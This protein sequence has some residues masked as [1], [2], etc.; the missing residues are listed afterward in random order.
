VPATADL[1]P[2]D[3]LPEVTGADDARRAAWVRADTYA[4]LKADIADRFGGWVF[5]AHVAMLIDFLEA[6]NPVDRYVLREDPMLGC[7]DVYRTTGSGAHAEPPV[8]LERRRYDPGDLTLILRRFVAW[9]ECRTGVRPLLRLTDDGGFE[10]VP[11]ATAA[12]LTEPA[13]QPPGR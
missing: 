13:F 11:P 1:G 5:A 6:L 12:L 3:R 4:D 2:V 10:A 9:I 8:C 7:W